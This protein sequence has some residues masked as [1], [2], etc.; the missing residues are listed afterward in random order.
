VDL[1]RK[2]ASGDLTPR[3]DG[4]IAGLIGAATIA[5]WFLIV[6]TLRGRPL[7]TPSL[8]GTAL[9]RGR[10]ALASPATHP[11]SPLMVL[12]FTLTH[13]LI[14]V[15]IGQIAARLVRLAEKNANY[16]FGIILFLVF[17]LSGFFFVSMVFEAELLRALTWPAVL[18]GNLLAVAAMAIYFARRHPGFRMLP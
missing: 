12:L 6:D 1:R 17:F 9:F 7:Y 5:L 3:K 8:L 10:D 4:T 13:G 14:F 18:A 2:V 11:I 15:V 16:G